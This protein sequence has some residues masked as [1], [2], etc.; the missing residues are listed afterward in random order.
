MLSVLLPPIDWLG[1]STQ[2]EDRTHTS[3]CETCAVAE[4]TIPLNTSFIMNHMT[5]KQKMLKINAK[6][7]LNITYVT[8]KTEK[9]LAVI[10]LEL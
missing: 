9:K 2:E 10:S 4:T 1:I 8:L 6:P 7:K 3:V 5:L